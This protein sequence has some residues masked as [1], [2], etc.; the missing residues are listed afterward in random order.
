MP[1]SRGKILHDC[2][3]EDCEERDH[4]YNG[5]HCVEPACPWRICSKCKHAIV[6]NPRN[7]HV[8]SLNVTVL[9]TKTGRIKREQGFELK[10]IKGTL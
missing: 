6:V 7:V 2:E 4:M 5:I 1:A 10:P 3:T 9:G 8:T